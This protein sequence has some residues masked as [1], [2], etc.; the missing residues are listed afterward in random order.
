[1]KSTARAATASGRRYMIQLCK[2][3]GHKFEVSFDDEKGHIALPAGPLDMTADAE[4]L[5]LVLDVPEETLDRL[6]GVVTEHLNRF[7]FR[8]PFALEWKRET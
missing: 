6:E 7:A 3:W 8:E 2:H 1:M 4:G 5:T